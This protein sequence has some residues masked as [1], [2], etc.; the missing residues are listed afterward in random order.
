MAKRIAKP[1]NPT[2]TTR[3]IS[4]TPIALPD[5]R[6]EAKTLVHE[7]AKA[8]RGDDHEKTHTGPTQKH[9]RVNQNYS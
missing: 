6:K 8:S 2:P 3:R 9:Q 7:V 1:S 5:M 4:L